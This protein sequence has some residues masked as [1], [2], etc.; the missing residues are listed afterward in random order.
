MNFLVRNITRNLVLAEHVN[1]ADTLVRRMI[2]LLGKKNLPVGHGLWIRKCKSVHTHFMRFPI[3]AIF[4]SAKGTVV[5]LY[6]TLKPFRITRFVS[7]AQDV[8]ELPSGTLSRVQTEL[9][10]QLVLEVARR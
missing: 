9:G 7:D 1:Q 2:G 4:I 10:D 6:P 5:R 8:L 3:D